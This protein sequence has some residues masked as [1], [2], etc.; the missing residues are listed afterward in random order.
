MN[1]DPEGL[2]AGAPWEYVT[3]TIHPHW[4][5]GPMSATVLLEVEGL[6]HLKCK[7]GSPEK[8][9][10]AVKSFLRTIPEGHEHGF[11]ALFDPYLVDACCTNGVFPMAV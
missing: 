3:S 7:H 8:A 9:A 11:S 10:R 2:G 4:G 6:T 1:P 5:G